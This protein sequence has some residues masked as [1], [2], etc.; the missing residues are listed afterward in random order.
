MEIKVKRIVII[1]F[2]VSLVSGVFIGK[3]CFYGED[4]ENINTLPEVS[5]LN[6]SNETEEDRIFVDI[7]GAVKRPG[8]YEMNANQ[9]VNDIIKKAGGLSKS[10]Y[11]KNINLSQKL[12]D[13]MVIYI[14]T[15]TE[16]KKLKSTND[17]KII[18]DTTCKCETIEVNNCITNPTETNSNNKEETITKIININTASKEEL[19]SISGLGDSK[20]DAI[21]TYRKEH[22]FTNI[23]E[24]K[25]VS[26]IGDSVFA[27]IKDY[28]TV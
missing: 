28:I 27:K 18:T 4:E 12:K 10:A 20:A 14:F 13:E 25:N 11:T 17:E 7:K 26:G 24:I 15:T 16:I 8:V 1:I 5:A 21:I 22:P 23:E 3:L 19:M 6:N 2:I 9:L